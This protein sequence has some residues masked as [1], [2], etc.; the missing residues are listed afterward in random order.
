MSD[1][2]RNGAFALG[3]TCGIGL[4]LNLFLWLDYKALQVTNQ[5]YQSDTEADRSAIGIFLDS[6]LGTFVNPK[7]GL[8]QW[9]MA[10]LSALAAY[11]LF[12]TLQHTNKTNTAAVATAK[13]AIETNK[14]MRA[15]Q[16]PW[17]KLTVGLDGGLF[18]RDGE[19]RASIV[20][21]TVNIGSVPSICPQF[22]EVG[23]VCETSDHIGSVDD[24][25]A[26]MLTSLEKSFDGYGRKKNHLRRV[27]FP[28]EKTRTVYNIVVPPL[29]LPQG[30]TYAKPLVFAACVYKTPDGAELFHTVVFRSI[31][32]G[33]ESGSIS[34][35]MINLADIEGTNKRIGISYSI[36]SD[37]VR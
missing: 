33:T 11:F 8:A 12:R 3:L 32:Q 14:I 4:A 15:E 34:G 9:I 31:V 25:F 24:K 35:D 5:V 37:R 2:Y 21:E 20:I 7:D 22:I 1:G 19:I 30:T 6:L 16:R 13:A 27:I 17:L 29:S 26:A 10:I 23:V 18:E 28:Q 36:F